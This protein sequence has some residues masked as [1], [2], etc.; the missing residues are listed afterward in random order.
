MPLQREWRQ[1]TVTTRLFLIGTPCTCLSTHKL[2][3]GF[4]NI[5][6]D[7]L[8]T[9]KEKNIILFRQRTVKVMQKKAS[10][11]ARKMQN[12]NKTGRK[13][14]RS[15]KRSDVQI[16]LGTYYFHTCVISFVCTFIQEEL[17]IVYLVR[18]RDFRA[19]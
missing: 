13:L 3:F 2:C 18:I 17:T 12:K 1:L 9:G 4:F 8:L 16:I 6:G 5:K 7:I 10:F 19:V 15:N 11:K 14:K